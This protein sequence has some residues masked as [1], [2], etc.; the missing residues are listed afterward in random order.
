MLDLDLVQLKEMLQD[1]FDKESVSIREHN[2]WL[3]IRRD[4]EPAIRQLGN[5]AR[6]YLYMRTNINRSKLPETWANLD[7]YYKMGHLAFAKNHTYICEDFGVWR[8]T[9]D[10]W[11]KK[12]IDC[13]AVIILNKEIEFRQGNAI[14]ILI[15]GLGLWDYETEINRR[16]AFYLNSPRLR[17]HLK[18]L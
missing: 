14:S 9:I 17:N 7:K 12:L 11:A 5:A 3:R 16:E 6:L 8:H 10:K 13:G 18:G 15:Y 4:E 2:S 1:E